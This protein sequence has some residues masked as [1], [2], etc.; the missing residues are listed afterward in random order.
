M[1]EESDNDELY[2]AETEDDDI[3]NTSKISYQDMAFVTEH[4]EKE[5]VRNIREICLKKSFAELK[6]LNE[7]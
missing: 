3:S 5:K 4:Q 6:L 7:K 2:F 1:E